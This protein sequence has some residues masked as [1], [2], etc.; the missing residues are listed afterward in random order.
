MFRGALAPG[1]TWQGHIDGGLSR[2]LLIP[3][4]LSGAGDTYSMLATANNHIPLHGAFASDVSTA[5]EH[6]VCAEAYGGQWL[7]GDADIML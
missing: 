6:E 1:C 2:G 5:S 3:R 7:Q 4:D